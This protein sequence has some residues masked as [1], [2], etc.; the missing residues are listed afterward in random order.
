MFSVVIR[1]TIVLV[2]A[3]V[4]AAAV[5][6]WGRAG[7]DPSQDQKFF[8]LLGQKDIPP[9]DGNDDLI[10]TAH[11][12]CSKLDGGMA[13]GDMVEVIRNN[14]FNDNPLTRL[15]SPARVT[16][17][18]DRFITA[19]VQAYCP[20]DQGKI[21]SI[22]GYFIRPTGVPVV[23]LASLDRPLPNGEIA[24]TKPLP[25]PAQPPPP[26]EVLPPA[27][28]GPPP[29]PRHVQPPPPKQQQAPPQQAP[30]QEPPAEGDMPQAPAPGPAPAP[31]G[32][33]GG[34]DS[35]GPAP[36]PA[37]PEPPAPA[38]PPPPGHIRLAP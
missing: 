15:Q 16:R 14:G 17:T 33:P 24:P 36:A 38:A 21:A 26:P 20:Y 7:A 8:D 13:V 37:P 32:A 1:H 30:P 23:V 9:V 5:P 6:S 22:S 25:V 29:P 3:V 27:P 2:V 35:S 12:V 11:K 10:I 34:G 28:E 4:L 31:G 19:A 18:I